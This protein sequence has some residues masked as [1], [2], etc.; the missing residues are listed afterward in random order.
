MLDAVVYG[1]Y[2]DRLIAY[3]KNGQDHT[4]KAK[5]IV[6]A[7]GAS[8]NALAFPGCTLP[9]VMG[10]GAAQ[11]MINVNRVLPGKEIIMVD[12]KCGSNCFLSINASR[13]QSQG[14]NRGST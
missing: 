8:E 1:I 11:T 3:I 14:T 6:L 5:K 13:C 10:A 12:L 2:E 9:G 7:T 4:I